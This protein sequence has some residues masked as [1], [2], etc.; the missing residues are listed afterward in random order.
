MNWLMYLGGFWLWFFVCY[1]IIEGTAKFIDK[2]KSNI[3]ET[4]IHIAVV[5]STWIWICLKFIR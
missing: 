5:I 4:F 2:R 1:W 3:G